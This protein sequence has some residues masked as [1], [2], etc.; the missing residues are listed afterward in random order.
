MMPQ[1]QADS[2]REMSLRPE[3][4]PDAST[5]FFEE[6]YRVFSAAQA[7][8][9]SIERTFSIADYEVRLQFAGPALMSATTTALTHLAARPSDTPDL[10]V[11]IWD[12]ASTGVPMIPPAWPADAYG[13]HG[14]IRG[15][16]TERFQTIVQRA[17]NSLNMLDHDRNIALYWIPDVARVTYYE[18]ISPLRTLLFWWMNRNARQLVHAGAV[19]TP[20][21]GVLLP[22]KGGSGKST[23]ALACLEAGFLYVGDNNVLLNDD[24]RPTRAYSVYNSTSL[25]GANLEERLPRFVP[26]I[27]NLD[28]LERQKAFGFLYK[29]YPTQMVRSLPIRAVL[30]PRVT[31]YRDTE[32]SGSSAGTSLNALVPSTVLSL[33]GAGRETVEILSRLLE[34]LPHYTLKLGTELSQIPR[35]ISDLLRTSR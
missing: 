13:P 9:G 8:A 18:T 21:G 5:A 6:A 7:A 27:E 19:G 4:S 20:D 28:R 17:N 16:N 23:T 35:T 30:V 10:T 1:T 12:S 25:H 3:S 26:M 34:P 33:P 32:I 22:A 29:Q 24:Q 2:P 15:F 11:C 14:M 31:G